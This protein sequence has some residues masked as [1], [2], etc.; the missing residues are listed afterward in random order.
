MKLFSVVFLLV[1]SLG[2]PA[3]A[4]LGDQ[5]EELLQNILL[6]SAEVAFNHRPLTLDTSLKQMRM[7]REI[8]PR[9]IQV[10]LSEVD[11]RLNVAGCSTVT[12]GEN[13]ATKIYWDINFDGR[14]S[15]STIQDLMSVVRHMATCR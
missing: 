1:F 2:T 8:D 3:L 10:L 14:G 6:D 13:V 11:S 9:S 4:Y 15:I 12:P 5:R 7:N